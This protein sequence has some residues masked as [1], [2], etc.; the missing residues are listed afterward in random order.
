MHHIL[1]QTSCNPLDFEM[2]FS[3]KKGWFKQKYPLKKHNLAHFSLINR[4]FLRSYEKTTLKTFLVLNHK[5]LQRI[6]H[7]SKFSK[8]AACGIDF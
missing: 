5:M 7:E 8:R 4:F 6:R 1:N 3:Q 2:S